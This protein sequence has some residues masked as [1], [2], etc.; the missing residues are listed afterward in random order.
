MKLGQGIGGGRREGRGRGFKKKQGVVVY[1][2]T[3]T[4]IIVSCLNYKHVLVK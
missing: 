4:K 3:L 1:M 2:L